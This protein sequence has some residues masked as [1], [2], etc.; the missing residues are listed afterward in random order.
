MVRGEGG[1]GE[2]EGGEGKG[3]EE[4]EGEGGGRGT[5][6]SQSSP[7]AASKPQ[8]LTARSARGSALARRG[9][10]PLGRAKKRRF[11]ELPNDLERGGEGRGVGRRVVP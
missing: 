7:V 2:G 4:G 5:H 11:R 8:S 10:G 9:D 3:G 6:Q 1:G